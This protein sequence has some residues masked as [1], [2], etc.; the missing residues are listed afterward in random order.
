MVKVVTLHTETHFLMIFQSVVCLLF[1]R[2]SIGIWS[3][4]Y[5]YL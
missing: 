4:W 3:R 1:I 5:V 2:F